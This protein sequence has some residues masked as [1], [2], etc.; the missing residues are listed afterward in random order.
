MDD[1]QLTIL[2]PHAYTTTSITKHLPSS[3][4]PLLVAQDVDILRGDGHYP[5]DV[6]TPPLRTTSLYH[7]CGRLFPSGRTG[8]DFTHCFGE[9]W[10]TT[11]YHTYR[12]LATALT[13]AQPILQYAQMR[14]VWLCN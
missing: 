5:T 14:N 11:R 1:P 13:Q 7:T 3:P 4:R 12:L 9:I 6:S 2:Q 10:M 8:T